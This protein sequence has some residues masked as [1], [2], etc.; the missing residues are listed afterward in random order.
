MNFLSGMLNFLG[1]SENDGIGKSLAKTIG[2]AFLLRQLSNSINRDNQADIEDQGTELQLDPDTQNKIPVVYGSAIIGGKITDVVLSGDN[3][4]L[5]VCLTLAEKTGFIMSDSTDSVYTF[6]NVFMD[7]L[8]LQFQGDNVTAARQVD[9]AGNKDERINGLISVYL[10]NN[11][12]AASVFVDD[13]PGTSVDARDIF[14]NWGTTNTMNEL[15]FAIVRVQYD[16]EKNL[17]NFPDFKFE[18][19][20]SMTLP[21]DCLFDYMTNTRYGAG[22]PS[23]EINDI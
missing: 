7:E 14:P 8:P 11:G 5:W 15:A 6:R 22:I 23:E 4:T 18:I 3:K 16:A 10:F 17:T 21:G 13:E 9:Y 1:P 20:N 12:S 2:S 19:E